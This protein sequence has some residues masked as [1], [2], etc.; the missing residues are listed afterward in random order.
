M[1]KSKI[2]EKLFEH[3]VIYSYL[4]LPVLFLIFRQ[5]KRDSVILAVYGLVFFLLLFFY[6]DLKKIDKKT[7]H[8][9]YTFLEYSFFTVL[10]YLNL[11]NKKFKQLITI[12][13]GC[14]IIFLII[15]NLFT[16]KA[17]VDSIPIGVE[18]ILVFVYIFLFFLQVLNKPQ[19]GFV[20][21]NHCFWI[22]VGLLVYLGGSFFINIYGSSLSKEEFDKFWYLN[23]IADTFKTI[24]FAVG[25]LFL[26]RRPDP[27]NQKSASVPYLDMI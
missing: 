16:G 3:I 4:I 7:Y 1:E 18:S 9:V 15:F 11:E 25:F 5:K 20:Y 14:F 21:L 17:R 27:V 13:S 26:A 23:Y 22:S 24:L 12:L 10:Y 2:I 8:A 6:E 19:G